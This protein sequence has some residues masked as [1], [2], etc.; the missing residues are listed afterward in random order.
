MG[1][2]IRAKSLKIEPL[3]ADY[4]FDSAYYLLPLDSLHNYITM[5]GHLPGVQTAEQ[6][7]EHGI[8]IGETQA[9]L[10]AKI[11]ELTLYLSSLNKTK[12]K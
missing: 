3:W 12:S 11:E 4:V 7:A 2:G 1:G 9:L 8:D 5:N 6:V 10:L